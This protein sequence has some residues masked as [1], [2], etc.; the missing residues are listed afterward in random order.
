MIERIEIIDRF[1]FENIFSASEPYLLISIRKPGS[2][3]VENRSAQLCVGECRLMIH[4]N[5]GHGFNSRGVIVEFCRRQMDKT[6]G[7]LTRN[8]NIASLV[9]MQTE[10]PS[11]Q[12]SAIAKCLVEW[13]ELPLDPNNRSCCPD[14]RVL[15]EFK[16]AIDDFHS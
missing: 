14:A 16:N 1:D 7:F 13:L 11:Q 10:F 9:V 12:S 3:F 5:D 15:A 2:R 6:I 8:R 4:E